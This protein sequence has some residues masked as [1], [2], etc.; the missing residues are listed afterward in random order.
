MVAVLTYIITALLPLRFKLTEEALHEFKTD[1]VGRVQ[2]DL[3]T[4][5]VRILHLPKLRSN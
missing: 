1:P 4:G 3:K 5:K 2:L